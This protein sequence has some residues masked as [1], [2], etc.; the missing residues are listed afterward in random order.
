VASRYESSIDIDQENNPHASLVRFVGLDKRVL[1]L[2]A[3]TG[4]MTEV[5]KQRGCTVTAVEFD[6]DAVDEL[7]EVADVTI[8]GDLNDHTV[9][10]AAHGPFDVVLAGDVLEH[11]LDP[12]ATLRQC[13]EQLGPDGRAVISIPNV[14]HS[15]LALALAHGGWRYTETG[16]LDRTHIFFFTY[17]RLLSVLAEAGLIVTSIERSVTGPF[18]TEQGLESES[19]DPELVAHVM[20]RPEAMTYQFVVSAEIDNGDPAQRDRS[21]QA[22]AAGLRFEAECRSSWLTEYNHAR[23]GSQLEIAR[24][25]RDDA[26]AQARSLRFRLGVTSK[27]LDVAL[28]A[29]DARRIQHR[30]DQEQLTKL[31]E[32]LAGAES[33]L[34][35]ARQELESARAAESTATALNSKLLAAVAPLLGSAHGSD[36][37]QLESISERLRYGDQDSH[38]LAAIRGTRSFR[39]IQSYHGAVERLAPAGTHRRRV[40]LRLTGSGSG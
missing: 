25:D 35:A 12:L 38:E 8:V 28:A 21:A 22:L 23:G 39:L 7:R 10:Q 16:L 37:H 13:V 4:Y 29:A 26:R 1:E 17:D 3:A 27:Q 14:A 32:V 15:S 33:E 18:N 40:L 19:F 2:G 5:L 36:V 20:G 34:Q 30:D 31:R 6:L 24:T 11:L 9:L